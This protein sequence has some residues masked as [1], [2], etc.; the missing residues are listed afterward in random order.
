MYENE[1][2]F[3]KALAQEVAT[4]ARSRQATLSTQEKSNRSFVTDLDLD[5]EHLIRARISKAFPDDVLTGEELETAGG[6]GSR[7]WCIDPIDGTGNLVHGFPLWSISIGLVDGEL[8]A[9]GVIAVPPLRELFWASQGAGAWL[10]GQR[11]H[12]VDAH[13]FH[14]H[15]NVSVSTNALRSLD[16]RT[17]PGRIRDLGSACCELAFVSCGR[18]R[19][20][21][22]QGE[23]T[24]DLAA[25]AVI[26]AEAGCRFARLDG[27][28][29]SAGEFVLN[30]P[31]TS[32]TLIAPP[33]RLQALK[34]SVRT[35]GGAPD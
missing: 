34:A 28:F 19:A 2:E 10:D 5:I 7:R 25:G 29:L 32:P 20:S 27:P 21:I 23:Q 11:I 22:F 14:D 26:A 33:G 6:Q 24:H 13:R 12:S 31:I 1:L 9:V 30:A 4:L 18:V 35:R 16:A 17:I 3:A 8:P 15:D